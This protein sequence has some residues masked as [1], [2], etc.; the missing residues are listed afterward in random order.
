VKAAVVPF[1][2]WLA[3][4]HAVAPAPVC[5]LFSGVMIE[6]GLFGMLRVFAAVFHGVPGIEEERLR[7]A[8]AVLGAV[9][10]LG[11]A[12]MCFAQRHFK[13]ML[14][15]SSIAHVGM[16][17]LGIATLTAKGLAGAGLYLVGH[18][19]VKGSLFLCAGLLLHRLGS[20]DEHELRGRGRPLRLLGAVC[21][22][23][24]LGL[25]GFPP[26]GTYLG[27]QVMEEAAAAAGWAWV[28]PVLFLGSAVTGAA[29]LRLA[30]RVFLG[31]GSSGGESA[32]S[33]TQTDRRETQP[34]GARIPAVM[35]TIAVALAVLPAGLGL[36]GGAPSAWADAASTRLLDRPGYAD[37]VLRGRGPGAL[38]AGETTPPSAEA[39]GVSVLTAATAAGLALAALFSDRWPKRLR[40]SSASVAE[41]IMRPLRAVHS[42]HVG[43]YAMW[44]V[45]G[46]AALGGWL[47]WP[48]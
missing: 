1:H 41:T 21:G 34:G 8:L 29:V 15:F 12:L 17:L 19:L 10:T 25:A 28:K 48:G 7:V 2:F 42:G 13:R 43:D 44:L 32:R 23:A 22:V 33:P 36:L 24:A 40:Q 4:A 3:D 16:I 38:P 14:A 39:L 46:V 26:Y 9:T 6:L 20:V 31:W 35:V 5:V 11:G 27:K 45:V 18:G 37:A 30:A 47:N